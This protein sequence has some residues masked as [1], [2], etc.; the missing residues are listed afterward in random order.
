MPERLPRLRECHP[1]LRTLG[2]GQAGLDGAQI[3]RQQ[4]GIF[5]FGRFLV[6]EHALLA[7]VGLD[8]RDLFFGTPGKPQVGEAFF[9]HGEDA[10]SRAILGRHVADGGAVGQ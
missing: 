3:K 8:Q 7:A 4:L 1:V 9:I 5:R 6:M 2:P 10:A